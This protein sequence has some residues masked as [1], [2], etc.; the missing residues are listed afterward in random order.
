M[1]KG[2]TEQLSEWKDWLL[3]DIKAGML[4]E[5]TTDVEGKVVEGALTRYGG[6]LKLDWLK[7]I[8]EI[9]EPEEPLS[10]KEKYEEEFYESKRK[11]KEDWEK[12]VTDNPD[13]YYYATKDGKKVIMEKRLG[14]NKIVYTFD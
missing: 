11:E 12:K 13:K 10:E 14:I 7:E 4:W 8:Y 6:F 2:T 1:K 9:E 5:D 3:E